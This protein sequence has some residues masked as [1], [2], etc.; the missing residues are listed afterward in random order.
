ML[1]RVVMPEVLVGVDPHTLDSASALISLI[2]IRA[3]VVILGGEAAK[4]TTK[5]PYPELT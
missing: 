2:H 4:I 1:V 3:F 5:S